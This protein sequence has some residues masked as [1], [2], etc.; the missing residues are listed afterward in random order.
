MVEVT[1]AERRSRLNNHEQMADAQSMCAPCKLCGGA[2]IIADAGPGA[3]YY[4]RCSNS[5]SFR[6]NKGCLISDQRLG[7]W[8]YNV[9]EWWNRLHR[10]QS[11][12][13]KDAR[14]A[15]LE[16]EVGHA[17]SAYDVALKQV[18]EN[19]STIETLRALLNGG[20]HG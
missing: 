17:W 2:A 1:E 10:T 16:T 6:P 3:G 14:I 15:E 19:A 8:A 5:T 11:T 12:A 7:G 20:E 4:I 18:A 13:A 9:M